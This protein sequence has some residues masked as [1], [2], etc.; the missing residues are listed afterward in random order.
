MEETPSPYKV[1]VLFNGFS[2]STENGIT[3]NC[4]C[5]LIKA[6]NTNIVVDTMT[7]WDG[8]KLTAKLEKHNLKCSDINYVIC[9][10]GHSDH[11]GCNYLFQK[12]FIHI[13]GHCV[14]KREHYFIHDFKNGYKYTINDY[15]E[16]IPTPGHTLQDVSVIV[17]TEEG[18]VA[19]TGDLFENE[20]DLKNDSIWKDA[21]SD[22]EELQLKSRKKILD[23]A[24]WIIPGHGP[25]FKV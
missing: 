15:V 10:H 1:Y 8:D 13:V 21:G 12:A 4:T 11:V 16:V 25:K 7:A 20:Q 6:P 17:K 9:T 23:L 18:I 22:S 14:S 5:T 19:V 3:A 2:N 24:D